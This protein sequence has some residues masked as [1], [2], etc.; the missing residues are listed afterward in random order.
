MTAPALELR[1]QSGGYD[2]IATRRINE[3]CAESIVLFVCGE[4]GGPD[5]R[6]R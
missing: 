1:R 6:T 4:P 2:M 5:R 3:W